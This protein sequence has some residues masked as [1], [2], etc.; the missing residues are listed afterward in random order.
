MNNY[1]PLKK[2]FLKKYVYWLPL[3]TWHEIINL[4]RHS[5]Y[6]FFMVSY[7]STW[8][9]YMKKCLYAGLS[10]TIGNIIFFV[11]RRFTNN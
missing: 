11:S 10:K 8:C 6:Q 7:M 4:T 9:V 1:Q 5:E 3:I 2:G